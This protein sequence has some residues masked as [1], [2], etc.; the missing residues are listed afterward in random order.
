MKFPFY[1]RIAVPLFAAVLGG[2]AGTAPSLQPPGPTTL[3][4]GISTDCASAEL[5]APVTRAA[6]GLDPAHIR[7]LSWN[8]FKSR[9]SGWA[10]DFDTVTRGADLVVLQEA[11]L[12]PALLAM[13][14]DRSLAWQMGTS[15]RRNGQTFGVLTAARSGTDYSCNLSAREPLLRIPKQIMVSRHPIAGTGDSLLLA[16][17]H[18]INFTI[19]SGAFRAQVDALAGVL[20]VHSGPVIVVGDF[21]TWNAARQSAVDAM[22]RNLGLH[23][24]HF[25]DDQRARFLG[26]PVDHILFRGLVARDAVVHQVT[27]SDHNPVA[28][29]FALAPRV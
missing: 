4:P 11:A 10:R 13:L 22:A 27:T 15:F 12:D 3:A 1:R 23:V 5:P 25:N 8:I 20:A 21:N 2:C 18:L 26:K 17:V 14:H 24:V 29:D 16:N 7:L 28:V 19:G 9:R 6:V